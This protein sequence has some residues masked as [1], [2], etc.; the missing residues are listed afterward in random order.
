MDT[1]VCGRGHENERAGR[2]PRRGASGEGAPR[3][4][5]LSV[6]TV[7]IAG[8]G[9]GQ[10][11]GAVLCRPGVPEVAHC[12]PLGVSSQFVGGAAGADG[13]VMPPLFHYSYLRTRLKVVAGHRGK[14]G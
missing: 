9:A 5:P 14:E 12:V 6:V 1:G 8:P 3:P 10:G 7:H 2:R 4:R 11:A 13:G